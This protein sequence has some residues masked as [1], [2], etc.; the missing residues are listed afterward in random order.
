MRLGGKKLLKLLLIR[1]LSLT[2]NLKN[3]LLEKKNYGGKN[4]E[5][6]GLRKATKKPNI[7]TLALLMEKTEYDRKD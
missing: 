3:I 7:F 1:N 5:C 6:Y 4:Q 2:R